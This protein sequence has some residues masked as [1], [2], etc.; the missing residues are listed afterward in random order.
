MNDDDVKKVVALREHIIKNYY[1]K[2]NHPKM[3][4]NAIMSEKDVAV[5]LE[6]IVRSLDDLVSH[7]VNFS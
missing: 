6:T 3:A 1:K 2:L 7:K 4:P 5:M